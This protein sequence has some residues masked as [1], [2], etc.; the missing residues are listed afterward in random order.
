MIDVVGVGANSVD[1]VYRLPQYPRSDS[2][3]AKLPITDYLVSCGGQVTTALATTMSENINE[4]RN[5]AQ[6]RARNAS[7]L[8]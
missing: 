2:A 8:S 5:W 3:F 1:F 7:V 6:G 4:L